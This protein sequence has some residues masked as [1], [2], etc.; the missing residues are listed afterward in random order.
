M[1]QQPTH[2]VLKQVT[3]SF[4]AKLLWDSDCLGTGPVRAR[5]RVSQED[6]L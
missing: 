6:T 4:P 1:L 2:V 3:Y 5:E